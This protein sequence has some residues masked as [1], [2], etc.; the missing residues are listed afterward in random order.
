MGG[1]VFVNGPLERRQHR[2][3][4]DR[5]LL[6]RSSE[7]PPSLSRLQEVCRQAGLSVL[8]LAQ[9]K[10]PDIHNFNKG[11][12]KL[13]GLGYDLYTEVVQHN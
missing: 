3:Q 9:F 13:S 2:S 4:M 8:F 6:R 5:L 12:L 7:T 10:G 11:L 1:P